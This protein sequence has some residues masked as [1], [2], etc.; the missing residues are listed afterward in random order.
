MICRQITRLNPAIRSPKPGFPNWSRRKSWQ[1][2]VVIA[3]CCPGLSKKPGQS[4]YR[5]QY[6]KPVEPLGSGKAWYTLPERQSVSLNLPGHGNILVRI[7]NWLMGC[8]R[9]GL[10]PQIQAL[11]EAKFAV[12]ICFKAKVPGTPN[13]ECLIPGLNSELRHFAVDWEWIPV[14]GYDDK[15]H[16]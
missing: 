10:V 7:K 4:A 16:D 9:P 14:A 2:G 8:S 11:P 12:G 3:S 5:H 1:P 15:A 13:I 6:L